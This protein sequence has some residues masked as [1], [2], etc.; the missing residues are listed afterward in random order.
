MR[1]DQD[2][3]N[4][5]ELEIKHLEFTS[6]KS[7]SKFWLL[8]TIRTWHVQ[9]CPTQPIDWLFSLKKYATYVSGTVTQ[10]KFSNAESNWS[11]TPYKRIIFCNSKII[12]RG[13]WCLGKWSPCTSRDMASKSRTIANNSKWNPSVLGN[14]IRQRMMSWIGYHIHTKR[15]RILLSNGRTAEESRARLSVQ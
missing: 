7:K 6:K 13:E 15:S 12:Q 4:R 5:I 10:K 14:G 2:T 8:L 3:R 9:N 1:F 11:A